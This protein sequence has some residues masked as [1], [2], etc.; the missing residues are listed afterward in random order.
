MLSFTVSLSVI[1]AGFIAMGLFCSA[2]TSNQVIAAV[3]TF[4]GMMAHLAIYFSSG[5][6]W[7]AGTTLGEVVSNVNFVD[8]WIESLAATGTARGYVDGPRIAGG[9]LFVRD[10]Q[11]RGSTQVEMIYFCRL[12]FSAHRARFER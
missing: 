8:L 11:D 4:V 3:F 2:L 6:P 1:G 10:G 12:R 9:L 5:A 7:L